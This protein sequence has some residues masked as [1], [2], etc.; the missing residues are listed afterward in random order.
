M[1]YTALYSYAHTLR[2]AQRERGGG[3]KK[4]EGRQKVTVQQPEKIRNEKKKIGLRPSWRRE[5]TRWR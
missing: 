3:R 1:R 2:V 5:E 4:A